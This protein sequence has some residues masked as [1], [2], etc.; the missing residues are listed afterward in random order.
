MVFGAAPG[1]D[2]DHWPI[3]IA[4]FADPAEAAFPALIGMLCRGAGLFLADGAGFGGRAGGSFPVVARGA[5]FRFA[6]GGA[7]LWILAGGV[8]PAV[9]GGVSFGSPTA[10]AALRRFTGGIFPVVAHRVS[11]RLAA[12]G[13]DFGLDAGGRQEIM[14]MRRGG[15]RLRRLGGAGRWIGFNLAGFSGRFGLP[16]G[17][18]RLRTDSGGIRKDAA[19]QEQA[20]HQQ[21]GQEGFDSLHNR[22]LF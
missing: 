13:A 19:G 2:P 21:N 1:G 14:R 9:S 12:G 22:S 18:G 3:G 17:D 4:G 20:N 16:G 15:L 6:A 7:F 10:G 8:L 5:A 11:L